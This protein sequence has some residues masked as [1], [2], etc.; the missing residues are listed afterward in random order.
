MISYTTPDRKSP[1]IGLKM[2]NMTENEKTGTNPVNSLLAYDVIF[3][4]LVDK[5][6]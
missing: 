5:F 6:I 4:V 1:K 2:A 3:H